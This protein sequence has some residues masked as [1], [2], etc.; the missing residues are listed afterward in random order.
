MLLANTN[1]WG[2]SPIGPPGFTPGQDD[3]TVTNPAPIASPRTYSGS[4]DFSNAF[5]NQYPDSIS[6]ATPYPAP[7]RVDRGRI[8][9]QPP[10]PTLVLDDE[11]SMPRLWFRA[12]A[13]YWWSKSSPLPIP[14]VTTGSMSDSTPG[15]INQPGTAVVMGNQNINIP[16]RGGSR[17]TLGFSFDPAQTLGFEASYFSLATSTTSMGVFS[18]GYTSSPLLAFPFLN[19]VTGKE[20]ATYIA[21]PGYFPGAAVLSLQNILQGTDLN[22]IRNVAN[23]GG[24]RFDLLGGFRYINFQEGLFFSTSSPSVGPHYYGDFETF[25]QATT[26]NNFFG[27]QIGLR[28]SYDINRFYFNATTKLAM[29][30]TF[31]NV[32]ISGGTFTNIGG[33]AS[34]PGA[35]LSQPT[36]MGSQ[37]RQQFAVVPELNLNAGYRIRPWAS[38]YVGYSFLYIS[39]VARPG[40]QVSHTINPTQAPAI[41]NT[42]P[43]NLTGVSQPFLSV[44]STSF[45]AQGLNFG[46]EFRF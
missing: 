23:S 8:F 9:Q 10:E 14:V 11:P 21:L 42:F 19:A 28:T 17:F 41:N 22:F 27:G 13:L 35:Y 18:D 24:L 43:G 38:V 7:P 37:T 45:W 34:A 30:S 40:E 20:D 15:A 44:H 25:D 31:E 32:S 3:S 5:S 1:A 12:E 39:S 29:G 33:Y 46:L 2:Q 16:A 36:N 26:Y 6:G 4:S